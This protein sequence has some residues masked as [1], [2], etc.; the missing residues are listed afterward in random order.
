MAMRGKLADSDGAVARNSFAARGQARLDSFNPMSSIQHLSA[1]V[2][3]L[4]SPPP[5]E[6]ADAPPAPTTPE[7]TGVDPAILLDLALKLA[8]TTPRL[9][10]EWA[11]E[12]LRL[13]IA[14]VEQL[15]WRLRDEQLLEILG[16][17]GPMTYRYSI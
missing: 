3:K 6:R 4:V 7:D 15:F 9:T 14:L 16:Q 5:M 12:Q 8:N 17:S 2:M 10:T 1:P 13:P 11:A